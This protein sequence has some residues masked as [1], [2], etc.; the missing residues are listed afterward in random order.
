MALPTGNGT[1]IDRGL[2]A[3]LSALETRRPEAV[4]AVVLLTDGNQ[5]DEGLEGLLERA[6]QAREAGILLYTIGLG[7][8]ADRDL[9]ESVAGSAERTFMAPTD[10][11]LADIYR[12]IAA[13]IPCG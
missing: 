12:A 4:A 13:A 6:E 5:A 11:D 3:G 10:E 7:P 1:R 2:E 8:D 9:L